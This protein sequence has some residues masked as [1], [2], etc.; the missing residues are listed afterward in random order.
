MAHDPNGISKK[1]WGHDLSQCSGELHRTLTHALTISFPARIARATAGSSKVPE[2][3]TF[4]A[5]TRHSMI[6]VHM[7]FFAG[8]GH[9][10]DF[11]FPSAPQS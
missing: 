2:T 4:G 3:A 7:P 9:L 8:L 11:A 6:A 10:G 5:G 1:V